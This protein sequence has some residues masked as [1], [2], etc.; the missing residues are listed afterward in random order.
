MESVHG[1][2]SHDQEEDE[3]QNGGG[4]SG[5][6]CEKLHY[7]PLLPEMSLA[8][9]PALEERVRRLPRETVK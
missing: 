7:L 6:P 8:R 9:M 3:C 1:L 4:D 5:Q 2:L